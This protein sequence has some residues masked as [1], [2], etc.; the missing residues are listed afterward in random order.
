MGLIKKV[1]VPKYFAAR[2]AMRSNVL[3]HATRPQASGAAGTEPVSAKASA[4]KLLEDFP[5]ER[6]SSSVIVL[7]KA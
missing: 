6:S 5:Q 1:D 2:R 7:P 4:A 3:P